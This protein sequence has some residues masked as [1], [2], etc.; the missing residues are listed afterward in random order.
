[1]AINNAQHSFIAT[2]ILS[3]RPTHTPDSA[4]EKT[5]GREKMKG[6]G[7]RGEQGDQHTRIHE[8]KG[9]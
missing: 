1:L 8:G 7:G 9:L 2:L 3:I 5:K 6:E 4:R